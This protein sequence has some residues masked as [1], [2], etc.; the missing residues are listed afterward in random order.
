[1]T[2][3]GFGPSAP[4]TCRRAARLVMPIC[5][6]D[7]DIPQQQGLAFARHLASCP[8]CRRQ[9]EDC[10]RLVHLARSHAGSLMTSDLAV[11]AADGDAGWE[12]LK[13]RCPDLAEAC[14]RQ[15]RKGLRRKLLRRAGWLA[16]AAGVLLAIGIGWLSSWCGGSGAPHPYADSSRSGR[17]EGRAELVT[18]QG[19]RPLA[20]DQVVETGDRPQEILLAGMHRVTMNSHTI[21][22]FATTRHGP[23]AANAPASDD[24]LQ[25]DIE[26]AQGEL[27]VEVV[28][29]HPFT[30]RT[31]EAL[32]RITGTKFNVRAEQDR[33]EL[34]L[35]KGSVRFSRADAVDSFVDVTA[36]HASTLVA[37]TDPT[38]PREV[39]ALAAAAWARNLRLE[40]ILADAALEVDNGSL[41]SIRDSLSEAPPPDLD[42]IDYVKWRDAH[43]DW[44]AREFPWIFTMQKVLSEQ[45]GIEADYIDLL[46]VSGDIWQFN[47]PRPL[48]E[49]IPVFDPASI[50]RTAVA[51]NVDLAKLLEAVT[52]HGNP[53]VDKSTEQ[54]TAANDAER[55]RLSLDRWQ[56][57]LA[58]LPILDADASARVL[59]ST[60][61]A[62][63]YLTNCRT[64]T[65]A[66][67]RENGNANRGSPCVDT[68]AGLYAAGPES[69]KDLAQVLEGDIGTLRAVGLAAQSLLAGSDEIDAESTA[70]E[71]T[72]LSNGMASLSRPGKTY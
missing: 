8:D 1:M 51:Y 20:L 66:W 42:S 68:A 44:F 28:P 52:P 10:R 33:T 48:G 13:R 11:R 40:S 63:T 21:A 61:R 15:D 16:A 29:G 64:A 19:N 56:Q 72:R 49:P 12:D 3:S 57:D 38:A 24:N 60:L 25:Y 14:R 23:V 47:Y 32:L 55:Y 4:L 50:K 53:R 62:A 31:H 67:I 30:V 34:T 69:M 26:L 39:D 18:P 7:P 59:L 2:P 27:F 71:R 45:H 9:Y 17:V 35:L 54:S 6:D 46:M 70:M 36:G 43:R 65:H 58:G 41:D 22:T 5:L 37:G